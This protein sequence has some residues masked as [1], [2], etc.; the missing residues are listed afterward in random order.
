MKNKV[1]NIFT[2]AVVAV[3]AFCLTSCGGKDEGPKHSPQF[4]M[5]SSVPNQSMIF[6]YDMMGLMDESQVRNSDDMP[7]ELKIMMNMYFDKM[8]SSKSMG[9]KLEG[10][11]HVVITGKEDGEFDFGF[12]MLN[13]IEQSKVKKGLKEFLKGKTEEEEGINYLTDKYSGAVAAWDSLHFVLAFSEDEARD[14]KSQTKSILGARY[15]DGPDNAELEAFLKREDDMNMFVYLDEW[16]KM[17]DAAEEG[18]NMDEELMA[19]YKGG[20]MIG[21]G[22]FD[23][24]KITFEME[25]HADQL[26][27]SKYNVLSKGA[28]ADEFMSYLTNDEL[29]MFG[30]ANL[31]MN[32]LM[33]VA[34]QDEKMKQEFEEEMK[35]SGLDANSVRELFTGEFSAS[36]IDLEMVPNPYYEESSASL[37]DD[38]FAD[39]DMSFV[40]KDIPKPKFITAVGIKDT[41]MMRELLNTIPGVEE[42]EDCYIVEDQFIVLVKNRLFI[43]SDKEIA[44]VLG[45]GGNLGIYKSAE[46]VDNPLHGHFNTSLNTLP[47][48]FKKVIAEGGGEESEELLQFFN[49]FE[50]ISFT[51]D[52]DRIKLEIVLTDKSTNSLEVITS[53]LMNQVVESADLFM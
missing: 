24:G 10:N 46:N 40:P 38:F 13:V 16:A 30:T 9:L 2:V 27:K 37:E 34:F 8:F 21:S 28:I 17:A 52:F 1:S 26:K 14:L 18:I 47:E 43:T 32:A 12:V 42:T 53:K 49:E 22:N 36:L 11:N 51:G 41:A 5:I 33:N 23:A 4:N 44:K 7:F 15:I 48:G 6:S 3:V 19:L 25:V 50:S 35:E 31:D 45:E 20:Y 29:I 39:M